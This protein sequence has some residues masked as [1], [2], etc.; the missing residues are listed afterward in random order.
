MT[1]PLGSS[2]VLIAGPY[3][4]R[5]DHADV[6]AVRGELA[7][8]GVPSALFDVAVPGAGR[9]LALADASDTADSVR[10]GGQGLG[11]FRAVWRSG[12]LAF[13][14]PPS[15]TPEQAR[16]TNA[17]WE[18]AFAAALDGLGGRVLDPHRSTLH[19]E[20]K[21]LQ[22]RLAREVGLDVPPTLITSDPRAVRAFAEGR[23]V[24]AKMLVPPFLLR[25]NDSAHEVPM[26]FTR[27]LSEADLADLRG[28]ESCP[29]IFQERLDKARDVRVTF[30]GE[31][32][33][34]TSVDP[35]LVPEPHVDWRHDGVALQ[36]QWKAH[37]LPDDVARK[38]QALRR[39]L[40]L[41]Y[42]AFD[43]VETPE[44]RHMFLELNSF[45]VFSFV[46]AALAAPIADALA[47]LL[48]APPA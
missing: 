13:V 47:E 9:S 45:A 46:G 34:P 18:M 25:K 41:R 29:M 43:L 10:V 36:G 17:A 24:V 22:L 7:R 6:V 16:A 44:G 30:V 1:V 23:R 27:A 8:R 19:A 33:F 5:P 28:L 26:V 3:V 15:F 37:A 39:Q 38:L 21:P 35:N 42:G 12:P 32:L 14:S 31:R 20:N 40:G 2:G 11:D 48:A 4:S